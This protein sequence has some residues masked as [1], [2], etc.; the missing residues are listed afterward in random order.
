MEDD[1]DKETNLR[2]TVSVTRSF[3]F[4]VRSDLVSFT[5][6]LEHPSPLA[7]VSSPLSVRTAGSFLF[8]QCKNLGV[9]ITDTQSQDEIGVV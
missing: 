2:L 6:S 9:K 3:C 5:S 7:I 1:R 4:L 8:C